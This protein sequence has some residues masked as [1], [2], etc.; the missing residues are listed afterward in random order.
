MEWADLVSGTTRLA[1]QPKKMKKIN[2][3][4]DL[5]THET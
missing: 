1:G 4:E 5:S 3:R 2:L